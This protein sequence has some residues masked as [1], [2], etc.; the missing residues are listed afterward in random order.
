MSRNRYSSHSVHH[1][2]V[3][4]VWITKYRYQVLKGDVQVRC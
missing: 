2:Q 3:H 4:L 1:L